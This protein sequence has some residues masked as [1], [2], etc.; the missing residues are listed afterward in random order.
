MIEE[1][2]HHG[3]WWLPNKPQG[4]IAGTLKFDPAKGST[5]EL[6]GSFNPNIS[7]LTDYSSPAI[8]LG[9]STK[10]KQITLQNCFE[11]SRNLNI[12]GMISLSLNLNLFLL[13][14][15]SQNPKTSCLREHWLSFLI[16]MSG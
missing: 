10:G 11:T 13:V 8:I 15:T 5:L 3:K 7:N 4:E 1:F 16:L 9:I 12:P 14:L 6:I 2:E